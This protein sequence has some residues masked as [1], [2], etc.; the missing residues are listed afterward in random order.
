[1]VKPPDPW[2]KAPSLF[3]HVCCQLNYVYLQEPAQQ[4][5]FGDPAHACCEFQY[6]PKTRNL[7][8]EI[9]DHLV[10]RPCVV[11]MKIPAPCDTQ[12]CSWDRIPVVL[13]PCSVIIILLNLI[14][15]LINDC[16]KLLKALVLPFFCVVPS[17]LSSIIEL[18]I[19]H[20]H[21][22]VVLNTHLSVSAT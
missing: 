1:M 9:V 10:T 21:L 2:H 14:R 5:P 19:V 18:F 16:P 6:T 11:L 4:S 12:K 3:N 22:R 17:I 8:R 7:V 13:T 20:K 15:F